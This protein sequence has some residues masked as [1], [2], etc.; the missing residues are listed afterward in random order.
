[1][2]T[3]ELELQRIEAL[4]LFQSPLGDLVNGNLLSPC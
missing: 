2:E 4:G 1:M 3:L